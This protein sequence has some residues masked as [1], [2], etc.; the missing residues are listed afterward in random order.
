MTTKKKQVNMI[1]EIIMVPIDEVKPFEHNA[2]KHKK[3]DIEL[4]AE[5]IKE[6]GW[7]QPIV[8]VGETGEIIKGHKRLAVAKH[9]KLKEVPVLKR[10][11]LSDVEIE[12]LRLADNKLAE[13]QWDPHK[14][15]ERINFLMDKGSRVQSLGF[16]DISKHIRAAPEKPD[17]EFTEIL[18]ESNNYIVLVF[19]N[20][21][22]WLN[23]QTH[24]Q[25]KPAR[26]RQ[27]KKN[28]KTKQVGIGR[29]INGASYINRIK[30]TD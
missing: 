23:A 29:V 5:H 13:S 16:S 21:L 9:L 2:K 14:L 6:S 4:L 17:V 12:E 10:F 28:D 7:D 30:R 24:F 19:D 11:G 1:K 25:L 20:E 8:I 26:A 22:D 27:W 3:K 15:R 18:C